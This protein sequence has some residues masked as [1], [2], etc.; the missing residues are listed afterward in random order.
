MKSIRC[1]FG[2][3]E[4][5][6]RGNWRIQE[7]LLAIDPTMAHA[8]GMEGQ[9]ACPIRILGDSGAAFA[10]GAVG[11]AVMQT[12][13]FV[14]WFRLQEGRRRFRMGIFPPKEAFVRK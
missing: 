6:L 2:R 4:Q 3:E 5:Q 7:G 14:E 9:E 10:M 13:N 8:G 1:N 12:W 11:G